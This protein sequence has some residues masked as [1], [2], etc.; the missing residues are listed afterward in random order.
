MFL[1]ERKD[2]FQEVLLTSHPVGQ[3]IAVVRAD[4]AATEE[5]LQ[6]MQQLRIARVLHDGELREH[7]ITGGHI[8]VGVDAHM[9]TTFTVYETRDPTWIELHDQLHDQ[10]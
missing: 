1:E 6:G 5:G 2:P 4:H 3:S 7:L 10:P 9:E 8:R